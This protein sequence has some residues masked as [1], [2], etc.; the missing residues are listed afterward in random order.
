MANAERKKESGLMRDVHRMGKK[1][2]STLT[3]LKVTIYAIHRAFS[4]TG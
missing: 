4:T 2:L 3:L 1:R